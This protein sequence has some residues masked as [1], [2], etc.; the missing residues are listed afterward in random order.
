[1]LPDTPLSLLPEVPRSHN[2]ASTIRW[3]HLQLL[4]GALLSDY[5]YHL[6]ACILPSLSLVEH[7]STSCMSP[8][9]TVCFLQLNMLK[10]VSQLGYQLSYSSEGSSFFIGKAP[11]EQAVFIGLLSP[12][13]SP[14]CYLCCSSSSTAQHPTTPHSTTRLEPD[15]CMLCSLPCSCPSTSPRLCVLPSTAQFS[16]AQHSKYRTECA[17]RI[18]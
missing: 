12:S 13:T 1:M 17:P 2:T 9:H 14:G 4:R 3:G 6:L 5:G 18:S 10:L 8:Q 11:A 7:N 16:T 15:D